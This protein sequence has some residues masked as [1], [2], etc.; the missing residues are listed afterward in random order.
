MQ[1]SYFYIIYQDILAHFMS[2]RKP[3]LPA[4][5]NPR[6]E[7]FLLFYAEVANIMLIPHLVLSLC[8]YLLRDRRTTHKL[9]SIFLKQMPRLLD[10]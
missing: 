6:D 10:V 2:F 5:N 7:E 8:A 4:L 3:V 9:L 1:P